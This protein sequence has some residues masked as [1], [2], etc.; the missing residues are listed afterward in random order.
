MGKIFQCIQMDKTRGFWKSDQNSKKWQ[1]SFLKVKKDAKNTMW[2]HPNN[3][4]KYEI[5]SNIWNLKEWEIPL[6]LN[7]SIGGNFALMT[8]WS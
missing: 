7:D 1:A 2:Q 6:S 4:N 3:T 8:F 5:L